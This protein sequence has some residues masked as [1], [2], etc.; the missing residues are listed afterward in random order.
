V[1]PAEEK[2]RLVGVL[3]TLSSQPANTRLAALKEFLA[4]HPKSRWAPA[5]RAL[6]A[7]QLFREGFFSS[8]EAEWARVWAELKD[9]DSAPQR[10]LANSA[11][12]RL[13]ELHT[14]FADKAKIQS[15]L[16]SVGSRELEGPVKS[17]ADRAREV[18]WY[19]ENQEIQNVL[20]GPVALYSI[21]D[22]LGQP[23]RMADLDFITEESIKTG[24]SCKEMVQL[25][26]SLKLSLKAVR[27]EGRNSP[28]PTPSVIH[29]K[30]NHY[31]SL[32]DERD[33][34]YL[35]EDRVLGF[36]GWV[37]R[38]AIDAEGSGIYLIP[39]DKPGI[40]F[41]QLEDGEASRV[42]GKHCAHGDGSGATGVS[43]GNPEKDNCEPDQQA[44]GEA[45][46]PWY[47][48]HTKAV[49]LLIRDTPLS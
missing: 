12:K 1:E 38:E 28:I 31:S 17:A 23:H 10:E 15:L 43:D 26:S 7:S 45:G 5:L 36:Y 14:S 44:G 30:F 22:R 35:L 25:A 40:G 20:C 29:W 46:M 3:N 34:R 24:I 4:L 21:K 19:L 2:S 16:A 32:L 39:V 42:F 49:S 6:L 18:I 37:S 48:F 27:T 41:R 33:G 47:S 8:A 11:L 13:L 9:R